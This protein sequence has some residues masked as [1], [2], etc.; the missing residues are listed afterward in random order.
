MA[1]LST[2]TALTVQTSPASCIFLSVC[3]SACGPQSRPLFGSR[4][5]TSSEDEA[6]VSP[7][8]MCMWATVKVLIKSYC[9]SCL[10]E[11]TS[12]AQLSM[13]TA[14]TVRTISCIMHL[15]VP[16]HKCL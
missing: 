8:H 15:F 5:R 4:M 16:L 12:M 14:L 9:F 7:V 11:S 2:P 1:P 13:P 10:Q 6:I 3:V